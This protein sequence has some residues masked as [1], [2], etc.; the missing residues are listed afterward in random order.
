MYVCMSV[1]MNIHLFCC[2]PILIQD[3]S[4]CASENPQVMGTH[5]TAWAF[6]KSSIRDMIHPVA[7]ATVG[8]QDMSRF[9]WLCSAVAP[10]M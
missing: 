9:R 1:C 2:L 10:K 6:A 8:G 5:G 3:H 7:R 4:T